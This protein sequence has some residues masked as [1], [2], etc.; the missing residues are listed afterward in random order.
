MAAIW[1]IIASI[2]NS[3]FQAFFKAWNDAQAR[4]DL[5]TTNQDVGAYNAASETQQAIIEAADER[6][7]LDPS[8]TDADDLARSLRRRKL[9]VSIVSDHA[10]PINDPA[11]KKG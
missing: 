6:A 3:L 8:P 9:S 10:S 5:E 2:L 11:G 4:K 7:N 1:S